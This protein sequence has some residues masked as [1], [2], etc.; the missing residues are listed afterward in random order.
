VT[1]VEAPDGRTWVVRRRWF[2]GG[3]RRFL[4][5]YH[6]GWLRVVDVLGGAM[7]SSSRLSQLDQ[8][9]W[10]AGMGDVRQSNPGGIVSLFLLPVYLLAGLLLGALDGLLRMVLGAGALVGHVVLRRPWTIEATSEASDPVVHRLTGWRA[11]AGARHDLAEALRAGRELTIGHG[12]I[13]N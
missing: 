12:P 5:G 9:A 3:V 4:A 13:S 11:S 6:R 2:G 1:T 8:P 7:R 10:T